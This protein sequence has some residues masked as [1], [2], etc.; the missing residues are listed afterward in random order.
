MTDSGRNLPG[1]DRAAAFS[2]GIFAIT[3]T[4]LV[5]EIQDGRA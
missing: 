2:D 1:T 3:I 5:L 4:L